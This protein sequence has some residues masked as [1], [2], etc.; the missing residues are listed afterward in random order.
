[1]DPHP[2]LAIALVDLGLVERDRAVLARELAAI[3]IEMR[4]VF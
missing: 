1:L 3:G 2:N 4:R